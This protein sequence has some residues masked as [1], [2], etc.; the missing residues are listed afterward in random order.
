MVPGN[1]VWGKGQASWRQSWGARGRAREEVKGRMSAWDTG[2]LFPAPEAVVPTGLPLLLWL[3][4][5]V[6]Q[7]NP[8]FCWGKEKSKYPQIW[9]SLC[10]QRQGRTSKIGSEGLQFNFYKELILQKLSKNAKGVGCWNQWSRKI[11]RR[12]Q[13]VHRQFLMTPRVSRWETK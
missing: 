5:Y 8:Y 13:D 4:V 3:L 1:L 10:S 6:I 2:L 9:R 12:N 11:R 7:I